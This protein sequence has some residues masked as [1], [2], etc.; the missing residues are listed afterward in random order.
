MTILFKSQAAIFDMDGVLVN[1]EPI[2]QHAE[3]QVLSEYGLDLPAI[4]KKY[5]LVTTGI[6]IN[7]AIDLY[8]RLEPNKKIPVNKAVERILDQVI[9]RVIETKP[10]LPGVLESL[11]LCQTL[12]LKIGLAS[13]SPMRLI[14]A[15]TETLNITSFFEQRLSAETLE[16][17]KPHPD[18]YLLTAEKLSVDRMKC[19]TLEDSIA[20]MIATK[21]A[22]MRSIVIPEEANFHN[23]KW[24]LA[25]VKLNSL[26][27]LNAQ[28]LG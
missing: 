21:A 28:H 18:V 13:S 7:E 22:G 17:G 27:E 25:D 26:M 19:V 8:S 5:G 15:V 20:G 16:Y 14:D 23:P 24:C 11:A 12:G 10:I 2:W 6:R 1:S 9:S 4:H 3:Q